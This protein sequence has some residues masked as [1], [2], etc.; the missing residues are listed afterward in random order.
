MKIQDDK[1]IRQ[2]IKPEPQHKIDRTGND[3]KKILSGLQSTADDVKETAPLSPDDI[4]KINLRLQNASAIA[5]LETSSL[6]E[7][8]WKFQSGELEKIEQFF[9]LLESYTNVLSDP[10]KNLRDIA[11]LIK[12]MEGET[13]KLAGLGERLPDGHVLKDLINKAAI[14]TTVEVLKFNRGD[15]L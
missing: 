8:I 4:Q 1:S 6:D 15:Y 3:F 12:S 2:V 9:N 14:L 7:S 11:P 10:K 13:E 5:G